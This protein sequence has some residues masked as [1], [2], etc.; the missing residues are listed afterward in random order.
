MHDLVKLA[1]AITYIESRPNIQARLT[2]RELQI[3]RQL[4]DRTGTRS[5]RVGILKGHV[6]L[7][8]IRKAVGE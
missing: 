1:D 5:M 6:S 4:M 2:R 8:S 7:E 3:T